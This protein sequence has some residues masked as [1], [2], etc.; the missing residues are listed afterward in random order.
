M[1]RVAL[2]P[3]AD[4]SL[5]DLR[6][7]LINWIV[8]RQQS[9]DCLLRIEDAGTPPDAGRDVAPIGLL[10]EKFALTFDRTLHRQDR[11]RHYRQLANTLLE[12]DKAFACT[13]SPETLTAD[14]A[15]DAAAGRP[16]RYRGRCQNRTA[17]D[18]GRLHEEKIPYAIR[19]RPPQSPLTFEDAIAGEITTEADTV[20]AFVLLESD[21]TPGGDFAT[22]V[23]DMLEGITT[24][25]RPQRYLLRTPHQIHVRQQL[26]YDQSLTYAHLPTPDGGEMPRTLLPLFEEGFLPDAI[27]NALLLAGNNTPAEVFTLPKAVERFD[28]DRLA[29]TAAPFS[30]GT[31][32]TLNREHL[33][34]MEDKALSLLYGFADPA[35]GRLVKLYLEEAATL[36]ELDEKIK[37]FFA[38]KPC[39]G[40]HAESMRR[41]AALIPPMPILPEY[42]A[43]ASYLAEHTGLAGDA[44][45]RPL[46][47][48]LT[49][50]AAG[51]ALEAIYPLIQSYI[52]EVARCPR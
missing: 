33:N 36:R 8:A 26:G 5:E 42:E 18:L 9:R 49:G 13:C 50:S 10:L 6:F 24:V 14:R 23:D 40:T 51:P 34:R 4:L 17:K 21:G 2:A 20:D 39:S 48:L 30:I 47:L 52:T 43:F 27:L 29:R 19:I 35:I 22:A 16:Y 7:A 15:E 3:A 37:P 25:I 38:P 1:L 32:R 12:Q 11:L 44:L 41:L 28:L 45:T 46:R 31:L